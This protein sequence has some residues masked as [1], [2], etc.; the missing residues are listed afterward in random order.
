[1]TQADERM[2]VKFEAGW[3]LSDRA[4]ELVFFL[5][6]DELCVLLARLSPPPADGCSVRQQGEAVDER[7]D[8]VPC[9]LLSPLGALRCLILARR[10]RKA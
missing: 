9:N 7:V 1:M 3:S 4:S 8:R 5:L 2:D 6:F 10:T